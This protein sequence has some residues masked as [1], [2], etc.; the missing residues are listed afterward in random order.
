MILSDAGETIISFDI[1]S[2]LVT[3]L[4]HNGFIGNF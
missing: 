2:D 3:W 4:L 1:F